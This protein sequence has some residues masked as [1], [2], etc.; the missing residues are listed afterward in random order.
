MKKWLLLLLLVAAVGGGLY[1]WWRSAGVQ[2]LHEKTL[3]FAEVR[4]ATIRDIVSAT[5]L[6]EP[7]ETV[8]VSSE[9]PGTVT[10]LL[11]RVGDPVTEGAEL[12]HLDERRIIL[13]IE[14]AE[15]GI[16][17]AESA[18]LQA[19]AALA[20]ATPHKEAAARNIWTRRRNSPRQRPRLPLRT[21][22]GQGAARSRRRR[23]QSRRGG[24]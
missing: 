11:G 9:I 16:K 12:A 8:V 13:K 24:G 20:Q 1:Y 23:R 14:E 19:E 21:R 18:I 17:M 2:P 15:T 3:T 6:V 22:T 5:G 4:R 7:R 10:R